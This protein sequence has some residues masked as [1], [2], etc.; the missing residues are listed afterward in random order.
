MKNLLLLSLIFLISCTQPTFE[1][2]GGVRV[3]LE[4]SNANN[5][6]IERIK[7][8]LTKRLNAFGI[9]NPIIRPGD[10]PELIV[11]EIPGKVNDLQRLRK[12]LQSSA[13]LEFWETYENAEMYEN[14]TK[15]NT[16]LSEELYPELKD[17]VVEEKV[18]VKE[19]TSMEEQFAAQKSEKEI[20]EER[21]MNAQ[22][23]NPVFALL[24]PSLRY[25]AR[26]QPEALRDGPVVGMALAKDTAIINS[27]LNSPTSKKIFGS[28]V[29]FLWTHEP[30]KEANG[31]IYELIAIKVNRNGKAAL[32]DNVVED[33][34]VD[35]SEFGLQIL[36]SMTKTAAIDWQKLTRDNVGRAIAI[37]LDDQVYSYPIVNGE[38]SGGKASISGNFTK[39]EAKDFANVLKVGCLPVAVGIVQEEEVAGKK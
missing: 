27:Y 35:D 37:V 17:T 5:T 22:K 19:G 2:A 4:A 9:D 39:Q 28:K 32:W 7:F 30:L 33:A 25:N 11:V 31:D 15:L 14:L 36:M 13:K 20:E 8:I 10:K 3:V 38:I 24:T 16:A 6:E 21:M 18:V 29:K 34:N 26:Q 1:E 12:L 23:K